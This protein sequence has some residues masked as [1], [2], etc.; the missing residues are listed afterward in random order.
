MFK[1]QKGEII[2]IEYVICIQNTAKD[3]SY[4]V[5]LRDG[6]CIY[7]AECYYDELCARLLSPKK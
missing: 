3:N 2:N 1:T 7:I 4:R 5:C 6:Y